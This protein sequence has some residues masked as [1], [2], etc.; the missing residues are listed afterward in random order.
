MESTPGTPGLRRRT[1]WVIAA[2]WSLGVL[3]VAAWWL[4]DRL[5]EHHEESAATGA[6]RLSGVKETLAITL[7]QLA[8]LP[9]DLSHRR[10]V[11]EFVAGTSATDAPAAQSVEIQQT[12]DRLSADFSLPLV[13]LINRRGEL[14]ASNE[15][16]GG[17]AG[18]ASAPLPIQTFFNEAM[19]RGSSIQFSADRD[20][21]LPEFYFASRVL[22]DSV[23]VG[24]A[25]VTQDT[26]TLNRLLSEARGARVFASDPNGVIVLADRSDLLMMRLPGSAQRPEAEWQAIYR[27]V[28]QPVAWQQSRRSGD[29]GGA[30]I[31]HLGGLRHVSLSSPLADTP[32]KIWVLE[33]LQEESTIVRNAWIGGVVVWLFG[34]ALIWLGWR[35]VHSLDAAVQARREIFELTQALPLTVFRYTRP[36]HGAPRFTFIGRGVEALFGVDAAKLEADPELPWRLAGDDRPPTRPHEFS[37]ERGDR[38]TWVLADSTPKP[39]AD[40]GTTYN[41]YW[42]DITARREAQARFAAVFEHASTSYLFFDA[43]HG[44]MHCNPAT[45]KLFGASEE[46]TLVGRNPWTPGLSPELQA[47]GQSSR[48]RALEGLREHTA[49]R[50]RVRTFEWRFRRLDGSEFDTEVSVI[51]LEWVGTPEFCA[52]IQDITARKQLQASMQ[53]ARDAAEAANQT[54]SSFLANMSHELRTPMNSIIGM[55]HL[56]LEDGLPDKQRDYI[57]KAHSSARNL[58]QILN[59]ILDVSKIEAGQLALERIDFE[60]ESVVSEM[61]DVLGLKADEK[62]LEL[63]FSASPDLPRRLVGD[64]T[65]LRQVLVNLGGNAIKFTDAGEVTVG[66]ELAQQDA[67]SVEVHAWVRDTGVGMSAD[68]LARLFQP[69]VQADSSTTR[70]YGGTGLGLVIS[71]Q[72]VERMGGRMWV[73]SEPGKGSTFHFTAR[74]GRSAP[75]AAARAWMANELRGQRALLVDDNAAALDVMSSMLET[76]GVVV[77]RAASGE[78]A[79]AMVDAQPQAYTWFLIDWKMPGM[80]GVACARRILEKHPL[81]RPCILLV[82]GF[83]RDDALRASA[84]VPLAGVLLKPVTPSSLHDCLVQA[85]RLASAAPVTARRVINTPPLSQAVRERLAGAR[86]LL[87]EDHPL[88]QQLASE[89]LHRAGMEVVL[90]QDGREALA[91]LAADGPFDG[92][93]MDCQMPVM[94]GYTATRELRRHPEWQRLPVIAMTASALAEDRDRALASGMNAHIAKPIQVESMLRTMADWIVGPNAAAPAHTADPATNG[95]DAAA[96]PAIDT[97]VGL[98]YCIGNEDLYRRLLEGFRDAEADFAADVGPAIIDRRWADALRRSHDLKG[99]AGTIG[100]QRLLAAAQV[101]HAALAAQ[102][103]EAAS[104]AL[105]RTGAELAAVLGEI[106]ALLPGSR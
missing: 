20:G 6:V 12:L 29:A 104:A 60:L 101:L 86:V 71:R 41:G 31:T 37:I 36:A 4:Q 90:A 102:H 5:A 51:A 94:D 69:F 79:L 62:G 15:A 19:A 25:V 27:R 89:L 98:S 83:A 58:L 40:G 10:T 66:M 81:V 50:Q 23:P 80:D 3:G 45:L 84:G 103:A 78:Q 42:L 63:L 7:R 11:P 21:G 100:A 99:L 75:R 76:L 53:Q 105:E 82:T 38:V 18:S 74:F 106:E 91:R 57:E 52:V 85:R 70:R 67:D 96:S 39:E 32:L 55:T 33:P 46:Q 97:A 87:V 35:R 30:L 68:E 2:M 72:L 9:H 26:G 77:D 28:P 14:L 44:L 47:D 93:L 17:R 59:D 95:A 73:D 56:A 49:T 88:N 64:P 34:C 65:R 48:T 43:R 24:V 22:R 61:A 1:A 13:A 92:V 54:K 16:S 8:A